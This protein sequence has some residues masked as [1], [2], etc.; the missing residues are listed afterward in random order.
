[1]VDNLSHSLC[2]FNRQGRAY[3]QG[4]F[5]VWLITQILSSCK[6]E[7]FSVKCAAVTLPIGLVQLQTLLRYALGRISKCIFI[8]YGT[9]HGSKLCQSSI[10][11]DMRC[12]AQRMLVSNKVCSLYYVVFW[13]LVG[14]VSQNKI[15]YL[16]YFTVQ[17]F[18]L[19]VQDMK[20]LRFIGNGLQQLQI[21]HF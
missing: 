3:G 1:M 10:E 4:I 16:E 11:C 18:S 2:Q 20:G 5:Q 15:S 21:S 12:A 7:M 14:R 9:V 17:H 6:I 13:K 8:R 19:W